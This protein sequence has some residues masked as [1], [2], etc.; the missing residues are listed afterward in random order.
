MNSLNFCRKQNLID[1]ETYGYL[2]WALTEYLNT[3]REQIEK[4]FEETAEKYKR[5]LEGG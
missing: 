5:K 1:E 4:D 3:L 2:R